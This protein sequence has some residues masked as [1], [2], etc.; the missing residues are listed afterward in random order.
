MILLAPK[1]SLGYLRAGR[2]CIEHGYQKISFMIFHKGLK[3]VPETDENY[4]LL[5]QGKQEAEAR[6][7]NR[8][9]ILSRLPLDTVYGTINQYFS[10]EELV[11]F[12]RVCSF[13]RNL[14]L[15]YPKIW[16]HVRTDER[17][18]TTKEGTISVNTLLP[19]IGQHIQKLELPQNPKTVRYIDCIPTSNFKN[20]QSIKI[21]PNGK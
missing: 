20:L 10:R 2:R 1:D 15:N 5:I 21:P 8:F 19:S 18:D 11:Q 9:D 3:E 12:T 4:R 13:W 7:N 6:Y 16:T 17:N 14:I